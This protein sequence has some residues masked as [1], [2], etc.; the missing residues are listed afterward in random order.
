[1]RR[2]RPLGFLTSGSTVALA[3]LSAELVVRLAVGMPQEPAPL[4]RGLPPL[5]EPD[6]ALGWR[7][8]AGSVVWPGRG[9]DAGRPISLSFWPGGRRATAR[10]PGPPRAEVVIVG[11]SYTQGW[12]VS[13]AET[14][15]WQLQQRFPERSFANLGTAGYGTYQSALALERHFAVSKAP[16]DLVVYGMIDHHEIRNVAPG[17]WIR[18]LATATAAHR[19][20]VPFATLGEDGSLERHVPEAYPDWF[21]D[22]ELASVAFLEARLVDWR[23]G[24][25]AREARA[26]TEKLLVELR[27]GSSRRGAPL[28]VAILEARPETRRHYR[29]FLSAHG[30]ASVDC[31]SARSLDPAFLVPG[32]GHP[33][34]EIH[35]E[36][37]ACI[38]DALDPMLPPRSVKLAR[39]AAARGS[40]RP[41]I[42]AGF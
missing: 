1:M 31:A 27:D 25:R 24:E 10:V 42:P 20:A 26:V 35:A 28:L 29:A 4:D 14:F 38:G 7:N 40:E 18:R 23:D 30:I 33:G 34:R 13:D 17:G 6:A 36:W 11:C 16:V 39:A 2:A 12:A 9:S 5:H 3:F 21:F 32:Y 15:A 37:A 8:K 22:D 41:E 19:L